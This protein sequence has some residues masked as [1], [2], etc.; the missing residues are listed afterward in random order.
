MGLLENNKYKIS[1]SPESKNT[2]GLRVGD[3][4]RRQ[5]TDSG[6]TIYTLMAVVETGFDKVKDAEGVLVDSPYFIGLLL[7]GDAPMSGEPLDFVRMTSLFDQDRSGALYMTASDSGAPYMSVIDKLGTESSL[8]LPYYYDQED[9]GPSKNK[10][11]AILPDGCAAEYLAS[12]DDVYRCLRLTRSQNTEQPAMRVTFDS[13]LQLGERLLI[14][15]KVRCDQTNQATLS[16]GYTDDSIAEVNETFE[17]GAEWKYN[18]WV[19]RIDTNPMGANILSIQLNEGD[20]TTLEVGELNIIRLSDIATFNQ[21]EKTRVGRIDGNTDPVFGTLRG[22]GV[23]S[24]NL[25]ATKNVG[26]AGTLTA[27][28]ENGFSST[29]YAGRIQKNLFRNSLSPSVA[30]SEPSNGIIPPPMVG[31]AI[32]LNS[33]TLHAITCREA[34]W[35]KDNANKVVT[36]SMW[37]FSESESTMTLRQGGE[38]LGEWA[39]SK[40]WGRYDSTFVVKP[41]EAS[42]DIELVCESMPIICAPQLEFGDH[43]TQYQPTDEVLTDDSTAYGFW[44]CRGG[45]GGTI[46]NPLLRLDPDGSLRSRDGNFYILAD[47]SA[48][49]KGTLEI[50]D[51]TSVDGTTFIKNGT[52]NTTLLNV[53]E[54][55]AT[56]IETETIVGA[57]LTFDK[58]KIGG[59]LITDTMLTSE[60]TE[61]RDHIELSATGGIRNIVA[62]KETWGLRPDGSGIL[63]SGQISWDVNGDLKV[64]KITASS[65]TI[66]GWN[67][68]T[69]Y[70]F[71]GT[72]KTSDGYAESGITI[73][74]NGTSAAIRAKNFYIGTDGSAHLKGEIEAS[75]GSFGNWHIDGAYIYSGA[76]QTSDAYATSGITL[77]AETINGVEYAALR[78]VN[79]RIDTNGNAYFKGNGEFTGK[80][81]A[82][83]GSIG[84][85]TIGS[86]EI[87]SGN[88]HL[89]SSGSIYCQSGS[90][91]KW[92]LKNDGSG[93][94][95]NGNISWTSGGSLTVNAGG[96]FSGTLSAASGSF[97]GSIT[98]TSGSI[99][100]WSIDSSSIAKNSVVLSSDG[101][102]YNSKGAWCFRN[103]G[104]GYLAG[105]NKIYWDTS[106]NFCFSNGMIGKIKILSES[107][108]DTDSLYGGLVCMAR[109][110]GNEA[111]DLYGT[112]FDPRSYSSSTS[113]TYL[114]RT[115]Y[116]PG[117][118]LSVSKCTGYGSW[119]PIAQIR[120]NGHSSFC[121]G[122]V[123]FNSDGSGQIGTQGNY[124]EWQ[125]N[126]TVKVNG[127]IS[128]QSGQGVDYQW[129]G[130]SLRLGTIP[131]GGGSTSWGSYV[132]LKGDKGDKGDTGA[133]GP[134]G[135]QG[136]A[137]DTYTNIFLQGTSWPSAYF[138][139]NSASGAIYLHARGDDGGAYAL[140]I[141][142]GSINYHCQSFASNGNVW[143]RGSLT[144][145]SDIRLKNRLNDV[146]N[147]LESLNEIQAFKYTLKGDSSNAIKIGLSAQDLLKVYPELV[148]LSPIDSEGN[149]YYSV[150]YSCLSVIALQACKELH[151][152]IKTQQT[153]I[154]ELEQ[155]LSA[156]ESV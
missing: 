22:Y 125:P 48:Y 117:G 84:G 15:F 90:T 45:I 88:M 18:L 108:Q 72:K 6:N 77:Y 20:A 110:T 83:S 135:P 102:I 1:I 67:I 79:F 101:S 42:F 154:E 104:S 116:Y 46:Q 139:A 126:G 62:S 59:W 2:Q 80:I 97:S 145:N 37:V 99:G 75:S 9:S 114:Y 64:N 91:V 106:G 17:V 10:Y 103:D 53:K 65:G 115:K 23:Y 26:I 128:G 147:V 149:K 30:N 95:A 148:E 78:G 87:S 107:D 38:T 70:L 68:E 141:A 136:P 55:Y 82:S 50:G 152:L 153:K 71:S 119:D 89:S 85:W 49:F 13:E 138:K 146:D 51:K 41:I 127:I 5:Y 74:A 11:N 143:F 121:D 28:D 96:T 27:G 105:Y 129:S 111:N 140:Y 60:T 120:F 40:G 66:A 52:I 63:A 43:P 57:N 14:S 94:L 73:Y 122:R 69:N 29:F 8:C 81:T 133:T 109:G 7:D 134:T 112:Y 31:N 32:Q 137:K 131:V 155:R 44:G 98:A 130:T 12:Q 21:A 118:G 150:N 39:L 36:F 156:L 100:G 61:G 142:H 19:V 151:S 25:Y 113:S 92:Q 4:V 33:E 24:Q 56:D 132:N 76:K 86:S 123:I 144:Q 124:I 35:G 34:G 16:Y 47:G 3:I 54:I 58:G 93:S